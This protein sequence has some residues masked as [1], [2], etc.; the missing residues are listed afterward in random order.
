MIL[1][2]S[3]FRNEFF[4]IFLK[5]KVNNLNEN[6]AMGIFI[7]EKEIDKSNNRSIELR[8]DRSYR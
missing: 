6:I 5:K 2:N 8:Y 3:I 7:K 1:V 4:K